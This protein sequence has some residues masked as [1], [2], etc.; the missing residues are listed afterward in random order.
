MELLKTETDKLNEQGIQFMKRV[1]LSKEPGERQQYVQELVEEDGEKIY[2]RW[3]AMVD[4]TLGTVA[5]G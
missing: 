3:M 5:L 1:A 2:K 4:V